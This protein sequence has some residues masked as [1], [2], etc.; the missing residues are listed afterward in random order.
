MILE[1]P[2]AG[3]G[4]VGGRGIDRELE[5]GSR[6][7]SRTF[8]RSSMAFNLRNTVLWLLPSRRPAAERLPVRQMARTTSRS[9]HSMLREGAG[10]IVAALCVTAIRVFHKSQFPDKIKSLLLRLD[11]CSQIVLGDLPF[12]KSC[13]PD[14]LPA[15]NRGCRLVVWPT[16]PSSTPSVPSSS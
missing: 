7:K 12:G 4:E 10:I 2:L 15:S 9:L 11:V 1:I 16:S 14:L 8:R 6:S 13:L 5:V 3:P